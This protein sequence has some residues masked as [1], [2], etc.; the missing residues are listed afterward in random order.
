M[1]ELDWRQR[2]RYK[3]N[4]LVDGFGPAAQKKLLDSR[5]LV[6]G[7][8]GLGSPAA[9]YLAAAGV[10]TLGLADGDTVELSNLQR[11]LLHHHND[12]GKAK[13]ASAAEKIASLNGDINVTCHGRIEDKGSMET[14]VAGY[15]FI[16]DATDNFSSKYLLNEACVAQEKPFSHAGI[17]EFGGQ[18]M[19]VVPGEGACYACIFG[20]PS[21]AEG[22]DPSQE[23]VIGAV[24]G[25]IGSIQ[26]AEALKYLTATG[27]LLIDTLLCC[28]AKTMSFRKIALRRQQN[29][30]VCSGTI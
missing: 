9:L 6:I 14:L 2:E 26:A 1:T 22:L 29:C 11:Q 30:P 21:R 5:I 19:T 7:L 25:I 16:V 27:E 15:D 4:L 3:R 17:S 28:N 10:G 8:G 12:I 23:G 13:T 24:A 20:E 18:T